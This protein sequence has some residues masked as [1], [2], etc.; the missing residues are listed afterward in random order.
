[1][2]STI[3]DIVYEYKEVENFAIEDKMAMSW[4]PEQVGLQQIIQLLK[5]SQSPDT[6]TQRSVQQVSFSVQYYA[7]VQVFISRSNEI[8]SYF[9]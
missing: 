5:E 3:L 7:Y 6:E 4:Q 2:P 9:L 8:R 1:M